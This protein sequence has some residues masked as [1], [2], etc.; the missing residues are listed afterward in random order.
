MTV[1]ANEKSLSGRP[2]HLDQAQQQALEDFKARVEEGHDQ[3]QRKWYN[4]TTLL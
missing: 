1:P 3:T 2:G 4:D